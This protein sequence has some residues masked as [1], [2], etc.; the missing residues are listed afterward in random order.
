M[1]KGLGL[2]GNFRGKLGNAVGYQLKDSNNKQTQGVRVYQP[3]VKNPKTKAQATQRARMAVINATYRVLKPVIDRGY[4]G[5]AYGN[6]T[7]LRWLSDNMKRFNGAWFAKGASIGKP[8]LAQI[9][10]GSLAPVLYSMTPDA[11]VIVCEGVTT[12]SEVNTLGKVSALL[13]AGYPSLKDGDQITLVGFDNQGEVMTSR[14]QSFII[15]TTSTDAT[16]IFTAAAGM[17]KVWNEDS[18]YAFAVVISREGSNGEHLRS[19]ALIKVDDS[20]LEDAPYDDESKEA[21]IASYMTAG[22]SADWEVEK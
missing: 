3:V 22:T 18:V 9:A 7:R 12:S 17:I 13:K 1:A 15:D 8:A 6:K 16:A 20:D 4:E 21:A 19:N 2:I 10:K 5:I 11:P 14:V